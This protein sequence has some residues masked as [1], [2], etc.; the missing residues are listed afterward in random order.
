M[1]SWLTSVFAEQSLTAAA[2]S[3]PS[4]RGVVW[5]CQ[6][7]IVTLWD[8][9]V[10][11]MLSS[12]PRVCSVSFPSQP[13]SW[14][15]AAGSNTN[16][17]LSCLSPLTALSV[18]S[19]LPSPSTNYGAGAGEWPGGWW[20]LSIRA[21]LLLNLSDVICWVV[22]RY[23]R[24]KLLVCL[25]VSTL[26]SDEIITSPSGSDALSYTGRPAIP[27]A[28]KTGKAGWISYCLIIHVLVSGSSHISH[29]TSTLISW[30]WIFYT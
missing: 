1:L 3:Q 7:E 8:C 21:S 20:G 27:P 14:L 2:A 22:K 17:Q 28:T 19:D 29:L 26:Q 11:V 6:G 25:S 15:D 9:L 16:S 13:V 24:S 30:T 12:Q 5:Y 10:V 23:P 4:L 18:S